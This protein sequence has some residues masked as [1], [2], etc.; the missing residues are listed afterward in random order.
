VGDNRHDVELALQ[1][2]QWL[3]SSVLQSAAAGHDRERTH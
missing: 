1:A 2:S 3:G